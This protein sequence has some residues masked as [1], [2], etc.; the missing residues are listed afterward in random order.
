MQKNTKKTKVFI[1]FFCTG[2]ETTFHGNRSYPKNIS[3][4]MKMTPLKKIN[5]ISHIGSPQKSAFLGVK[6]NGSFC[7][8]HNAD[9][10]PFL[11]IKRISQTRCFL[12]SGGNNSP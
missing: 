1:S 12:D 4:S 2:F 6:I 3:K 7:I 11:F 9:K 10:R 5:K 8:F